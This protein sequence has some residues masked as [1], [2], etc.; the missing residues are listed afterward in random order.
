[1]PDTMYSNSAVYI[2]TTGQLLSANS[3]VGST[4]SVRPTLYLSSDVQITG[5][6]GTESNPYTLS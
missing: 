5:G 2:S 6:A 3:S 1:M 4:Y